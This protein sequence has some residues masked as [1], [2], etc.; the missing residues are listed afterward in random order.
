[1]NDSWS[2]IVFRLVELP[3]RLRGRRQ[4]EDRIRQRSGWRHAHGRRRYDRH[5][6]H[7][8]RRARML[9]FLRKTPASR[10]APSA[11]LL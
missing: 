9:P 4:Y 5:D 11:P 8:S 3:A 7:D 6:S 10:T 2:M 1:M